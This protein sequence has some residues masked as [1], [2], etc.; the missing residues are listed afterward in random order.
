MHTPSPASD[1]CVTYV[2]SMLY[3]LSL[4]NRL[5]ACAHRLLAYTVYTGC[6]D[7]DVQFRSAIVE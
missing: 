4:P 7:S 5:V 3:R 1:A 6:S 2:K